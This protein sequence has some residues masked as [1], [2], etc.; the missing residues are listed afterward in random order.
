MKTIESKQEILNLLKTLNIEYEII[1]H[2]AVFTINEMLALNLPKAECIAKN[3][4]VRDDK[5]QNYF[6]FVVRE[7]KMI[8]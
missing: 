6:L 7:E 8:S 5:K 4:F 3:L 2:E 1:L